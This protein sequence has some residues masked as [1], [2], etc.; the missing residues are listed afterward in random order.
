MATEHSPDDDLVLPFQIDGA[1]VR[2]RLIRLGPSINAVLNRH[3]YPPVVSNLLGEVMLL[4]ALIGSGLKLRG[5]YI[6]QVKG[7]GPI[8]M[9]VAE[10]TAASTIRGYAAYHPDAL[11]KHTDTNPEL[12]PFALLEGGVLAMTIDQGPDSEPYQG[13]VTIEGNS[14]SECAMAYL[15]QSDQ[16][17]SSVNTVLAECYVRDE[18]GK[19]VKTW[20]G[21][22]IMLQRIGQSGQEAKRVIDNPDD[23]DN[24]L[25]AEMLMK[26]AEAHE[27]TDPELAPETLLYRLFHEDGVRVYEARPVEFGCSCDP[28]RIEA[29]LK[30]HEPVE[31]EEMVDGDRIWAQCQFCGEFYDFEP[32]DFGVVL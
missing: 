3:N 21:G 16:I 6:M 19:P 7:T 25:R 27:L 15:H 14:L 5:R 28:A 8:A 20:R 9:L 18:E 12:A 4:T 1:H 2:G 30:M 11:T 17:R 32:K 26:T 23:Q 31:L 13:I 29:I 10:Y 24:W 22:G